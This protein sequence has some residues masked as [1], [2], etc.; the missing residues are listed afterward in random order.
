MNHNGTNG[1]P[2]SAEAII[3]SNAVI[4]VIERLGI[5]GAESAQILG[6]GQSIVSGL[7]NR[8]CVLNSSGKEWEIAL[9]LVRIYGSL[10]S[11]VGNEDA[12]RD[13][14]RSENRGLNGVPVNLM[15]TPEG[16][17]SVTHYLEASRGIN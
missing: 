7:Q 6:L 3:L 13:W 8:L 17:V 12:A 11:I 1:S 16:L 10:G 4:R 5:T 14:L 15:R 9:L 2:S